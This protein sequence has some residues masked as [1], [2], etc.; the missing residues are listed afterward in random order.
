MKGLKVTS[1][2]GDYSWRLTRKLASSQAR[3]LL[4]YAG[5]GQVC[6]PRLWRSLIPNPDVDAVTRACFLL[7]SQS[8][9]SSSIMQLLHRV[10]PPSGR[11]GSAF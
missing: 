8:D 11:S 10:A 2:L 3:M 9:R 4:L 6:S 1:Q 5:P 7:Y